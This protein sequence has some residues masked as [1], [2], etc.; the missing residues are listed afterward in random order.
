MN[1]LTVPGTM[2]IREVADVL[3]IDP[4]T[5]TKRV[6]ELFPQKLR[7]GVT[8]YLNE[9]EVT[10]LKMALG[11]N[12]HLGTLSEVAAMPQTRLE[13]ALLVRQALLV[14]QETI[15]ELEKENAELRAENAE[16]RPKAET[17]DKITAAKGDVSVRELAAILAVPGLGQNNLFDL[18]RKDW[19]IDRLNRPY[20]R[21]IEAGLMYEK[22]YYVPQLDAAKSQLRIT[23]KGVVHFARKYGTAPAVREDLW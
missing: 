6:R 5:A 18:M 1:D 10:V 11:H 17:L 2:T 21:H 20:R 23:Q 3:G 14:Q 7:N 4:S 16:I 22:E 15:T 12:G 9:S 8:T 13:K 19:Y